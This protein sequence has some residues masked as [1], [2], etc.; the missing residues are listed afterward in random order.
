M[1]QVWAKLT[2][3]H[4]RLQFDHAQ[5]GSRPSTTRSELPTLFAST[6]GSDSSRIASKYQPSRK[7]SRPKAIPFLRGRRLAAVGPPYR[8]SSAVQEETPGDLWDGSE[9]PGL[10]EQKGSK[11]ENEPLQ[12]RTLNII[13]IAQRRDGLGPN[14]RIAVPFRDVL[15]R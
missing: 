7:T 6:A 2:C 14:E 1:A 10:F 3:S 4:F 11:F 9:V 8:S 13:S 5:Y 15:R 12:F